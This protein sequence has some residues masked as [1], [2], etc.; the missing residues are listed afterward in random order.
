MI[1]NKAIFCG[2]SHYQGLGLEYELSERYN[3]ID[4]LNKNGIQELPEYIK[5][6]YDIHRKY[7]WS[8]LLSDKLNLI[9]W[10]CADDILL[11]DN[12]IN[13]L[14]RLLKDW[15]NVDEVKYIFFELTSLIRLHTDYNSHTAGELLELLNQNKI[16]KELTEEIKIWLYNNENGIT[17]ESFKSNFIKVK[18]KYPNIKFYVCDWYDSSDGK[19]NQDFNQNTLVFP[20]YKNIQ[21][22]LNK[23]KLTIK[24]SAL[25]Y[26]YKNITWDI[27]LE[28]LHASK[29]GH[30]I[31]S[32]VFYKQINKSVI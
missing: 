4:W 9:E 7:R 32:E 26:N 31:I 28:D 25:C 13:L 16:P 14:N 3:S 17:Y 30:E 22:G 18:E 24:D 8:K 12:D 20:N 15:I 27:K 19:L 6:D 23:E 11:P 1:Q 10:N 29:Q 21:E 2:S 5:S